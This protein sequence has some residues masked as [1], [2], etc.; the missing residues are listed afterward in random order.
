MA[1]NRAGAGGTIGAEIAAHAAP[2]GY[3]LF[4]SSTAVQ[5][6]APQIYKKLNY[7]MAGIDV[8]HVP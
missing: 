8:L 4:F 7:H 3:T 2:D 6:I 5:V 1:D